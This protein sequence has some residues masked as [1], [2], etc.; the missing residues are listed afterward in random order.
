M[1]ADQSDSR[2]GYRDGA[3]KPPQLR[4]GWF[5]VS[6]VNALLDGPDMRNFAVEWF[7]AVAGRDALAAELSP[8]RHVRSDIPPVVS[9]H[10]DSDPVVPYRQAQS[11]HAA[12]ARAGV[13]NELVSVA[14]GRHGDFSGA[15][16]LRAHERIWR[17]LRAHGIAARPLATPVR[18]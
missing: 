4:D 8:L 10:G 16:S 11:L 9:I 15:E 3:T 18:P 14:G 6:D 12:L 17:F 7:G 1:E 2:R 13:S 5:G